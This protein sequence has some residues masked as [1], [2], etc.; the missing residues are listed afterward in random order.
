[1]TSNLKLTFQ[2]VKEDGEIVALQVLLEH[3]K[4]RV[5]SARLC[6]YSTKEAEEDCTKRQQHDCIRSLV[7][8]PGRVRSFDGW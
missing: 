6:S 2:V 5:A 8:D 7:S 1:V 4:D 3:N